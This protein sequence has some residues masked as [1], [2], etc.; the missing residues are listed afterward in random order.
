VTPG[1]LSNVPHTPSVWQ[2]S[3]EQKSTVQTLQLSLHDKR[4]FPMRVT[5]NAIAIRV[6]TTRLQAS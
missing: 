1:F 5:Q 4:R 3:H 2:L 6:S